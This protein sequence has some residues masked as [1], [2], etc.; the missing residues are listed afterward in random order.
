MGAPGLLR[1]Y[2]HVFSMTKESKP[3]KK[4]IKPNNKLDEV[5]GE[6]TS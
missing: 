3:H 1:H 4:T 6:V 2:V 5:P